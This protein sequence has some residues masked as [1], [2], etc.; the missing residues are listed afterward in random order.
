[1]IPFWTNFLIRTYAWITLLNS[2]GLLNTLLLSC[3]DRAA[4]RAALHAGRVIG[5]VYT[6]LPFMI[7]PIYTPS[8]SSTT[9]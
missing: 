4:A 2:E 1:M 3:S 9:R 5:L 7:L 6:Y 8:K